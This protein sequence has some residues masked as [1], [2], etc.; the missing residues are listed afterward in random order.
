MVAAADN[1]HAIVTQMSAFLADA[2]AQAAA[3][4]TWQK[5][6]QMLVDLLHRFVAALDAISGMTGP[7]KKGLVLA[8]AAALFDAVADRC[9][10]AALYPF[11]TIIRPATRTLVLAIA[12]GAVESL[13][14]ITRSA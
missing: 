12:S 10:P 2:R 8:A 7:E 4:M 14:P 5:F 1:L 3:G 11:W 13:L 9:V 6:G